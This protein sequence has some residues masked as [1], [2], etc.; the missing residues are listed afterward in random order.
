MGPPDGE[1]DRTI[2]R[3]QDALRGRGD[4]P[5]RSRWTGLAVLLTSA[6]ELVSIHRPRNAEYHMIGLVRRLVLPAIVAAV[7]V[8]HPAD[9]QFAPRS[10][11][12]V[13]HLGED[14]V[15]QR[16]AAALRTAISRSDGYVVVDGDD[17]MVRINIVSLD[18][19]ASGGKSGVRSALSIVY[20]MSNYLP[21]EKGNPQTWY[22]IFLTSSIRL[23]GSEKVEAV[24][25]DALATLESELRE[26]RAA[27]A[28]A[29]LRR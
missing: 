1:S 12:Q 22:P 21:L 7:F 4:T 19:V 10:S 3:L 8:P 23:V 24:A 17:H 18:A 6:V 26:F 20:T 16:V 2:H 5:H 29:G 9:A 11:V 13:V 14:P 27:A 28:A 15:G 25:R